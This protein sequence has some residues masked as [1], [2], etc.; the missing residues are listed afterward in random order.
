MS[1]AE[2]AASMR[3]DG[4]PQSPA[5]ACRWRR[6]RSIRACE[7][8]P[9]PQAGPSGCIVRVIGNQRDAAAI[10][11]RRDGGAQ[12]ARAVLRRQDGVGRTGGGMAFAVHQQRVRRVAPGQVQ[13]VHGQDH[14]PALAPA[15]IAQQAQDGDLLMQVQVRQRLVE[16]QH[17]RLLR[18][19]RAMA[20]R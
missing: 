1:V 8:A 18:H 9:S 19:H 12:H 5:V 3:A 13:V 14:Q 7:A 20:T 11:D 10:V 4:A 6:D 17:A 16:Q 15:A 2:S